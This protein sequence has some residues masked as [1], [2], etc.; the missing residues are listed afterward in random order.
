MQD[1]GNYGKH[2]S[3]F[4][5]IKKC[6]GNLIDQVL[7]QLFEDL[8]F[9]RKKVVKKKRK[10]AWLSSGG[11]ISEEESSGEEEKGSLAVKWW[12]LFRGRK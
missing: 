8:A 1:L 3:N 9:P 11:P 12:T 10:A 4:T 7:L 6:Y 2:D 5:S